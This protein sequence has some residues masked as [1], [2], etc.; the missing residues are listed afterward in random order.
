MQPTHDDPRPPVDDRRHRLAGLALVLVC[1]LGFGGWA[2]SAELAVSVIASGRV[3]VASLKKTVQHLEGGIVR[4]IAVEEGD[5]VE[6]G[7]TLLVLDPTQVESRLQIARSQFLINR[8]A[9]TR[10]MAEQAGDERLTFPDQLADAESPRIAQLKAVQRGLFLSRREALE[11]A[12]AS[13]EEQSEQLRQ[14]IE[15]REAMIRVSREQLAS[16]REDAEAYRSLF[17]DGLGDNRRLRELEREVLQYQGEI[18]QH[19]TEIA[20]LRSQISENDLKKR[21]RVEEFRQEV[22]ERLRETRRQIADAEERMTALRDQR[23]RTTVEA[24]AAGTVVGLAVHTRGAVI[25]P[26]TTLLEIVPG[27]GDFVVEARVDD[28]DI[29]SVYPGQSAEIRFSAFNRRRSRLLDG[30]VQRVSADSFTDERSGQRYYEVRIRVSEAE[31]Q[32]MPDS[33]RL[34]AGMPAEVRLQTASR[35]F[36]SYLAKPVSDMLARAMRAD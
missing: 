18:E 34:Q 36:A 31:R 29:D 7:Q 22:G 13:L 10:L 24:P 3:E 4:R 12:L 11:G 6:E 26:G 2:V 23:R 17:K 19:R 25:E 15:G 20:R 8:A 27:G 28:R 9:E 1:V 32:S 21:V 16:L 14:R 30:T 33:M 35:T 5:R